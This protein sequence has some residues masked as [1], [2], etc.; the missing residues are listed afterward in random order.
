MKSTVQD[1]CEEV[2]KEIKMKYDVIMDRHNEIIADMIAK[3]KKEIA[4]SAYLYER[5]NAN[6]IQNER[7]ME[8]INKVF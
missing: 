8:D 4:E 7:R 6:V 5:A 2:K 3:R 1:S